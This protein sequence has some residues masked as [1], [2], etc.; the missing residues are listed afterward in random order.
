V[1]L[2]PNRLIDFLAALGDVPF[3]AEPCLG[4]LRIFTANPEPL[5]PLLPR[6]AARATFRQNDR[7]VHYGVSQPEQRLIQRLKTAF[8]PENRLCPLEFV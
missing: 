6:F 4:T 1:S 5:L 7:I 3:A 2:A 8:D